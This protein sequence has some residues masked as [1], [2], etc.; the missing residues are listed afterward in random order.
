M[1]GV[2]STVRKYDM[3]LQASSVAGTK[4]A[5]SNAKE[6]G[7]LYNFGPKVSYFVK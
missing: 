2:G 3:D 6:D 4:Q 5:T 1:D 7:L